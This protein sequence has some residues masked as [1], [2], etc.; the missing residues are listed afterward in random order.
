MIPHVDD[1]FRVGVDSATE[2]GDSSFYFVFLGK[3]IQDRCGIHGF[4]DF[5]LGCSI[6]S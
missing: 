2:D 3:Q 4:A 6:A 1:S 5:I